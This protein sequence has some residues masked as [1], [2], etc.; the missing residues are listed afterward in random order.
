MTSCIFL[1]YS[2]EYFTNHNKESLKESAVF[3][4]VDSLYGAFSVQS[5]VTVT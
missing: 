4:P 3:P 5:T 2:E 1:Y